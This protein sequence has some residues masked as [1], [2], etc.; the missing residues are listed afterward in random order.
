MWSCSLEK[1][2][3]LSPLYDLPRH[4]PGTAKNEASGRLEEAFGWFGLRAISARSGQGTRART[5]APL[6]RS[7]GKAGVNAPARWQRAQAGAGRLSE[8]PGAR[9][10]WFPESGRLDST[11]FGFRGASG[12]RASQPSLLEC[13]LLERFF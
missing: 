2:F 8:L 4:P 6:L 13:L 10:V 12:T 9:G 5:S 1:Y 11:Q 7:A 3:E